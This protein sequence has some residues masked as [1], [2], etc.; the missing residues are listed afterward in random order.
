[1]KTNEEN[2]FIVRKVSIIDTFRAIP[3]GTSVKYDCRE[4]GP[5]ASARSAA[6]RLN[7][8]HKEEIYTVMSDD[9][10]FTYTVSRSNPTVQ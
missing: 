9:N 3:P 4:L 1:M 2:S 8:E 6:S 5:M 10:G 7:S